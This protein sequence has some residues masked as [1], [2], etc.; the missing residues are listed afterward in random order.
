MR[1]ISFSLTTEQV[2]AGTKTSTLRRGWAFAKP[3]DRYM[4]CEKCQ[5]IKKGQKI[6]KIR[7]I[8]VVSNTPWTGSMA[9]CT[10]E[11]VKSEGFA[12]MSGEAFWLFLRDDLR[13]YKGEVLNRLMFKYV[14]VRL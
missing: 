5:G 3:G 14:P 8:E 2:R 7:V 9:A 6:V 13:V 10:P 12:G 1:N 11:L 4:G